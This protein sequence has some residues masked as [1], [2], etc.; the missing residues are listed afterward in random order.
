MAGPNGGAPSQ[1]MHGGNKNE[2]NTGCLPEIKLIRN[3][4]NIRLRHRD[5][6]TIASIHGITKSGEFATHILPSCRAL[7]AVVAEMHG[8]NEHPLAWREPSYVLANFDNLTCYVAS[9]YVG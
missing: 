6:L 2:R 5:Q 4:N 3:R 7:R 1:H 9:Q 8:S